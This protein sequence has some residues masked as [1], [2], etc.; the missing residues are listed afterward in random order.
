M[1]KGFKSKNKLVSYFEINS[2]FRTHCP[3]LLLGKRISRNMVI[4]TEVEILK[5]VYLQHKKFSFFRNLKK[6]F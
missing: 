4:S 6:V 1:I 5:L 3:S 2:K